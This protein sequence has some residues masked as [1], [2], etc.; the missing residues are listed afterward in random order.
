MSERLDRSGPSAAALALVLST[1]LGAQGTTG[2]FQ[3][4]DLSGRRRVF[5]N[6]ASNFCYAISGNG[7]AYNGT[8]KNV[9]L[10]DRTNYSDAP[11]GLIRPNQ[12]VSDVEFRAV[13]FMR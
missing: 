13:E 9:A 6:P 3:Y 7:R 11:H 12:H 5:E 8:N 1:P 4:T 2:F 10:H